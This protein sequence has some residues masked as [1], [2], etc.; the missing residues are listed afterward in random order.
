[1]KS[2]LII[3]DDFDYAEMC[4]TVLTEADYDVRQAP[5][6][7]K[8]FTIM[9]EERFDLIL[10]DLNMPF[11]SGPRAHEFK[12]SVEVGVKTVKELAWVN[13][14]IS[15]VAMTSAPEAEV[16]EIAPQLDGIPLF[17]K[18]HKG[19]ELIGLVKT[20]T[21]FAGKFLQ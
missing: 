7:D 6:P 12:R 18:P 21:G 19:K 9:R 11:T 8:A 10:C 13:P 15:V 4:A 20:V 14:T 1:M 2:I 17:S 5:C 16:R 3:D